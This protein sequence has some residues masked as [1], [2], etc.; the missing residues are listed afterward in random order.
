M[1]KEIRVLTFNTKN[2]QTGNCNVATVMGFFY[3]VTNRKR[4]SL[5]CTQHGKEKLQ[6]S[7][8]TECSCR[9]AICLCR[10]WVERTEEKHKLRPAIVS[11]KKY[12]EDKFNGHDIYRSS[13][14]QEIMDSMGTWKEKLKSVVSL[15]KSH[16]TSFKFKFFINFF[17]FLRLIYLS[18]YAK[19]TQGQQCY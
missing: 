12:R 16:D 15:L 6:K 3:T 2:R 18:Y 9:L 11:R 4:S 7:C 17:F 14:C 1:Q 13:T 5:K 8:I 19:S 10:L